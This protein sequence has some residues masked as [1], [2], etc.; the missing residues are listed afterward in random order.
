MRRKWLAVI[1]V[2]LGLT[3]IPGL[4][5]AAHATT[6]LVAQSTLSLAPGVIY[7]DYLD[8]DPTNVIHVVRI[9]AG[10]RI[11]IKAVPA[12]PT[13]QGGTAPVMSLCQRAN[14]VACV[15]GDFFDHS[16][17]PLG[18][19]LVDAT[20]LRPPTASQQQL[21]LDVGNQFSIGAEPAHAVQSLG[22]TNY[23]ILRPGQPV[24]I[25][26]HDAFADGPHARTL[27]GWNAAGDR[28]LVT[29]EQGGGSAGMS[30]SQAAGLMQRLGATT[31]I[32]EDGG[33]SSQMVAGGT[34]RHAPGYEGRAVANIWA[35]VALPPPAPASPPPPPPRIAA[36]RGASPGIG[37][38]L[39]GLLKPARHSRP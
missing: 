17:A 33:G 19:E 28:F 38:L 6:G 5:R 27:V 15:N 13:G 24:A 23:A 16:G 37:R 3:V 39:N 11:V 30:L 18:G 34:L 26:E 32:N 12:S 8:T 31:A 21:W 1:A 2:V 9:S 29:V 14:A 36:R 22:A 4:Y 20:W 25:P 10:A 35:V 7:T